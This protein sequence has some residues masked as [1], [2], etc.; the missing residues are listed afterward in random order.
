M[1]P[2]RQTVVYEP[3]TRRAAHSQPLDSRGNITPMNSRWRLVGVMIIGTL[4]SSW[5]ASCDRQIA[6]K[7]DADSSIAAP[8]AVAEKTYSLN[9]YPLGDKAEMSCRA[10]T[11]TYIGQGN[12]LALQDPTPDPNKLSAKVE[13]GTD[14]LALRVERDHLVFLTRAA[15]E[16]GVAEGSRFPLIQNNADYLKAVE[17]TDSGVA[18]LESFVLNKKNGLAVWSRVRP[19]GLLRQVAP[20]APDSSTIYF[21]CT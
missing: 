21:R 17:S 13:D 4:G 2:A 12:V 20:A 16:A 5:W 15:L 7:S 19:A 9:P 3:A 6:P 18:T 11:S 1:E 10:I 8:Q 14:V